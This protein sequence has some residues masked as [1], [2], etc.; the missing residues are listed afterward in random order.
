MTIEKISQLVEA[1]I[2]NC[3][4]KKADEV[5]SACGSDLMSDVLAFVKDQGVLLTGLV[6]PQVVLT[7]EMMDMKCIIFVRGK[8]PGEAIVDLASSH[9]I[10]LMKSPLR[11]YEAC[12]IL[13]SEG[14]GRKE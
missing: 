8:Q 4:E 14:L 3:P 12:G 11:M 7:A 2:L 10:V 13:Y 6:N 1:E 9:G 5:L